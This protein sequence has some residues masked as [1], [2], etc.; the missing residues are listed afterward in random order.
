M[1]V[2]ALLLVFQRIKNESLN[3]NC[4]H[5]LFSCH[6]GESP[7]KCKNRCDICKDKKAVEAMVENFHVCS[8]QFNTTAADY[9][10]DCSDLYE[11]GRLQTAR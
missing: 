1:E 11:G 5:S 2:C 7:P 9:N 10:A 4:R 8:V 3:S 6:F